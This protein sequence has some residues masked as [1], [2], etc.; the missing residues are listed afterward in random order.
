LTVVAAPFE[1]ERRHSIL[2]VGRLSRPD[3]WHRHRLLLKKPDER[4]LRSGH[5]SLLGDLSKP[6]RDGLVQLRRGIALLANVPR[7]SV[8]ASGAYWVLLV[9]VIDRRN[10]MDMH[11]RMQ[12]LMRVRSRFWITAGLGVSSLSLMVVTLL[13]RDWI[14]I[15]FEADPDSGNGSFEWLIVIALFVVTTTSFLFARTEWRRA[16]AV[17]L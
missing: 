9:R 5:A 13:W 17:R 6:R 10:A 16:A 3:D 14:E 11:G 8:A 2:H 7:G 4:N 1:R 15:V 12:T